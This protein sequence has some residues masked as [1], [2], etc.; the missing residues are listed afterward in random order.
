MKTNN[1]NGWILIYKLPDNIDNCP[2]G[3]YLV[4]CSCGKTHIRR[5]QDIK[6]SSKCRNCVGRHSIILSGFFRNIRRKAHERNIEFNVTK[7]DLEQKLK[8]QNFKCALSGIP[9]TIPT[10]DAETKGHKYIYNASLDRRD[11]TKGYVPDNIQWVDK[12]INMMKQ[13]LSETEFIDL[14]RTIVKHNDHQQNSS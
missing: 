2:R 1:L 14:C 5:L 3:S 9:L 12:R 10:T 13:R 6:R 4:Q 8:N 11:S 7:L